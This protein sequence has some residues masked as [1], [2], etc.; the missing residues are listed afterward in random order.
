MDFIHALQTQR[1][2]A[3]LTQ[4]AAAARLHLTVK[5]YKKRETEKYAPEYPE[6]LGLLTGLGMSAAE[7]HEAAAHPDVVA[8]YQ[9]VASRIRNHT[10][11]VWFALLV[12]GSRGTLLLLKY[13]PANTVRDLVLIILLLI[14]SVL[15]FPNFLRWLREP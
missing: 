6:R 15:Y 11:M 7:A 1:E 8:Y 3:N 13:H 2:A 9:W 14:G 4:E 5:E 12:V 10:I